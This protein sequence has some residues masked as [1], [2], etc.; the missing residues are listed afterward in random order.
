M[1]KR[2][3]AIKATAMAM[4][5]KLVKLLS[6]SDIG[7][8]LFQTNLELVGGCI[9][10]GKFSEEHCMILIED[11]IVV[12]QSRM[13]SSEEFRQIRSELVEFLRKYYPKTAFRIE[14]SNVDKSDW[15]LIKNNKVKRSR[16]SF[17]ELAD[18]YGISSRLGAP[19]T[20][21]IPVYGWTRYS[22]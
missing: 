16:T 2:E 3:L 13:D 8:D 14:R 5:G 21:T 22:S 7:N 19:M 1:T 4:R 10:A 6:G 11:G 18:F 20:I 9:H 15:G 17:D 12:F